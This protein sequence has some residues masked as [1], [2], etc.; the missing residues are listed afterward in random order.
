[1][2]EGS[3]R[4]HADPLSLTDV[5]TYLYE[6]IATLEYA[7][8]PA[9]RSEIAAAADLDDQTLDKALAEL[10]RRGLLVQADTGGEPTFEP[11]ERG[12]SAAPEQARGMH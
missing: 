2:P 3:D 4:P 1:M 5:D 7:G 11:A 12:W 6:T 10:T 9:S 8:R